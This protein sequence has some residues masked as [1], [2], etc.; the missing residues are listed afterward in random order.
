MTSNKPKGD[1]PRVTIYMEKNEWK[2]LDRHIRTM[3][4][5]GSNIKLSKYVAQVVSKHVQKE[6]KKDT[7]NNFQKAHKKEQKQVEPLICLSKLPSEFTAEDVRILCQENNLSPNTAK[8][9]LYTWK[10]EGKIQ[11]V[12]KGVYKKSM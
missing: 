6:M 5:H 11:S 7:A 2:W 4:Y 12:S 10:K 3:I 9:K 8:N 1:K